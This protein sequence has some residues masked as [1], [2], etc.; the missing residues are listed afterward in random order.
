MRV[1]LDTNVLASAFG[2]RGLCADV[3]G[4]VLAE[5]ELV[6]GEPVIGE[7]HGVLR[8]K[9]GVPL[10]T[11]RGIE[12]LLRE[13]QVAPAPRQLPNLPL[14]D[15]DDLLV[16]GSALNAGADVFVTGDRE[17]LELKE[18][19]AGLRISSPREFWNAASGK[20]RRGH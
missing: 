9:F 5:H 1:F 20:R 14:S 7:L 13:Y 15:V 11:V 6:T 4:L 8:K 18:R 16:L 12:A 2:T 10:A 3:L 19:P 17:L